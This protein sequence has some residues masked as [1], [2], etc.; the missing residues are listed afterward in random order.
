MARGINWHH[1]QVRRM[2]GNAFLEIKRVQKWCICIMC[3]HCDE[4]CIMQ[5]SLITSHPVLLGENRRL[6][7]IRPFLG[8]LCRWLNRFVKKEPNQRV[9]VGNLPAI[10]PQPPSRCA[11]VSG[12]YDIEEYIAAPKFGLKGYIDASVELTMTDSAVSAPPTSAFAAVPRGGPAGC[13]VVVAPL[14]LKTGRPRDSDT[15]QALLYLLLM[16]ERYGHPLHWGLL[17]Y[18]G[19][20]PTLVTRTEFEL[21][22]LMATRNRLAAALA[23]SE[24]PAIT[25][26]KSSC[27]WCYERTSC[28][29]MHCASGGDSA[30]F[31]GQSLPGKLRDTVQAAYEATA[32]HMSAEDAAFVAKW[33]RLLDLEAA[34][35]NKHR[36]EIWAMTGAEREALGRCLTNLVITRAQPCDAGGWLYTFAK[37][38]SSALAVS[39]PPGEMLMLSVEGRHAGI[40]RGHLYSCTATEIVVHM[41]RAIRDGVLRPNGATRTGV[42]GPPGVS[43]VSQGPGNGAAGGAVGPVADP[44]VLWRL[45]KEEVGT[46][47]SRMRG[48]L[49][50]LFARTVDKD[51]GGQETPASL[52]AARLRKLIVALHQPRPAPPAAQLPANVRAAVEAQVAALALNPEQAEAVRRAVACEDYTLVLGMPGA[53]KTTAV[54]AMLR[55]LAAAGK[56]VLLTSYTNSAVDNVLLKLADVG[57]TN[58]VRLGRED[59]VHPGLLPWLP[60]GSR[61]GATTAAQL[62]ALADSVPI[63]GVSALGASDVLVRRR[64]FDVCIVDEAGQITLPATLGPLLRA[65]AFVLVG[66]HH[67]LPP[68]VTS[69]QAAEGGLD[70]P[71]FARLAAAH[72]SAVVTLPVQYRMAA[73]IQVLPNALTYD[74]QLRCGS[75]AVANA[76]LDI[77]M[78]ALPPDTPAWVRHAL[79]PERR[80]V[81]LDTAAMESGCAHEV[82]A[83]EAVSNPAEARLA[84][85]VLRA[86]AAV[87]PS[88]TLAAISP[89]RCQVTALERALLEAGLPQVESLTID[90]AQGRDKDC[91]VVSLVRS[92]AKAEA[93]KLLMDARRVNVAITRAKAK[94][95]LVG[96]SSTLCTLPLFERLLGEC[97]QRGWVLP[98]PPG[99]LL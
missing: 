35:V 69:K 81:F 76:R 49:L 47:T 75:A 95:V 36:P 50:S 90:R 66:D 11:S 79:D 18:K 38:D 77:V 53:G 37:A 82:V 73:D 92:N 25:E 12:V 44:S 32:G 67:Q 85:A 40:G 2:L 91:V 45:D 46:T 89:Y 74:G 42:P 83:G 68:L 51:S 97:R 55:A 28:M 27:E 33:D 60:G 62:A 1:Y 31:L 19:A 64:Q 17:V 98:L 93:G 5:C 87:V 9:K 54:I 8:I 30:S 65:K 84:I 22:C 59:R 63:V 71:L 24:M 7:F 14:E 26:M 34:S 13:Q 23:R 72:P 57:E 3:S 96:D 58:F 16:E 39:F 21:A 88:S 29:L 10:G 99:A 4:S 41:D 48:F 61:H 20:D 80:V 70:E 78:D 52:Q 56:R 43:G 6:V 15:A 94:L 86:A